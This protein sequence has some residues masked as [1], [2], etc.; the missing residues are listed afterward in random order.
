MVAG[1]RLIA[2]S[3]RLLDGLAEVAGADVTVLREVFAR[4]MAQRPEERFETT[5]A[6]AEALKLAVNSPDV[7]KG[8]C[9]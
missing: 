4:A 6:F 2:T 9:S 7:D 8:R 1:R 5:R 3:R